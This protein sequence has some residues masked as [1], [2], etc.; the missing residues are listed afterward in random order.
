MSDRGALPE[1]LKKK[2][3][4]L[5]PMGVVFAARMIDSLAN[6]PQT[7]RPKPNETWITSSPRWIEY[8][9]LVI[10][11]HHGITVEAL[12][13]RSFETA[14]RET[15]EAVDWGLDPPGSATQPFVDLAVT[16]ADEQVRKLSLKSTAAQRLSE[17]TAHI[18]KLTEAAWIQPRQS[19]RK[20]KKQTLEHFKAY[21]EAVDAIVMLRAFRTNP[22][23]MP[24]RYQLIEIPTAIFKSLEDAP[25]T[26]FR[27]V[28]PTIDCAYRGNAQAARVSPG[29]IRRQDH[30]QADPTLRVRHPCRL[31]ATSR[32]LL[33]REHGQGVCSIWVLE[34]L[35]RRGGSG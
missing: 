17:T 16:A 8:F 34:I 25:R 1:D 15:C 23:A 4:E 3:D 12:G 31:G 14:F 28:G 11:A 27:D 24:H 33:M 9:G 22:T 2:I 26:A 19:A 5:S 29:Q 13:G 35:L 18:S 21:C 10:S 32:R 30:R 6:P 7:K 20:R